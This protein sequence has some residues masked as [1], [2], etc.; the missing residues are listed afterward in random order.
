MIILP[1][2][3]LSSI[4]YLN[5]SVLFATSCQKLVPSTIFFRVLKDYILQN[6]HKY[7][8]QRKAY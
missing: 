6:H 2:Q 1:F 4:Q 8:S 5:W 7:Q 3:G